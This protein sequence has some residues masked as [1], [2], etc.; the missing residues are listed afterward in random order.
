MTYHAAAVG[1]SLDGA[2]SDQRV[3]LSR[4]GVPEDPRVAPHPFVPHGALV[5]LL[6]VSRVGLDE[7]ILRLL[8]PADQI[9]R[10]GR[11]GT[12]YEGVAFDAYPRVE[13]VPPLPSPDYAP[14]PD[15]AIIPG[16]RRTGAHS[17]PAGHSSALGP[18]RRRSRRRHSGAAIRVA[19]RAGRL[20]VEDVV[21][22]AVSDQPKIPHPFIGKPQGHV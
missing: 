16:P 18:S 14:G 5:V 11:S 20:K 3:V 17:S 12:L 4:P 7:G 19:Q 6:V 15:G 1:L 22:H 13:H 8:A 2:G 9:L 10:G 21:V